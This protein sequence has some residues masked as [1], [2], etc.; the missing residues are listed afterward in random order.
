MKIVSVVLGLGAV[1][2]LVAAFFALNAYIYNEKQ[3]DGANPGAGTS[4]SLEGVV[5]AV[6]LEQMMVDGPALIQFETR[7]GEMHTI[8]VPSMGIMLCAAQPQIDSVGTIEVGDPI[9]VRGTIGAEERII[10]CDD[11]EDYLRVGKGTYTNSDV[12]YQFSYEKGADGYELQT[13]DAMSSDTTFTTGVQLMLH[14]DYEE[15]QAATDAREGP[16][17]IAV[18][19]YENEG[20]QSAAVWVDDYA[21]ESNIT[22]AFAEPEEAVVGGANA[23]MYVSD[24]LYPTRT[25]VIAHGGYIFVLTGS[26]LDQ[27]SRIYRDFDTIVDSFTFIATASQM[28]GTTEL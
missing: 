26:Y 7:I 17:T 18:R 16:P 6:E 22:L 10:P 3:P 14:D 23:V 12:G 24:G 15:L 1:V 9:A 13:P 27:N 2:A 5:R 28:R 4:V 20:N 21:Q 11:A 19:V 25:Y 8:A